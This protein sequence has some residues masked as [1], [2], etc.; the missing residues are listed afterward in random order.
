M[1]PYSDT[2]LLRAAW[3]GTRFDLRLAFLIMAPAGILSVLPL[4][5]IIRLDFLQALVKIYLKSIS[6]LMLLFY[7]FD[8]GHYGYLGR[9]IDITVLDNLINPLISARMI[10]ESYSVPGAVLGWAAA[11]YLIHKIVNKISGIINEAP[12]LSSK[13]QGLMGLVFGGLIYIF[14]IWGTFSQYPLRWSDAFFSQEAFV[15]AL[16]INP[17][18]YFQ[19]TKKFSNANFSLEETRR[20]Y[21]RMSAYLSVN[22]SPIDSLSFTRISPGT[23]GGK[24]P[25]IVIIFLESVGANRM[26]LMGN[27]LNPSPNLDRLA[28]EGLFFKRFYVP[29]VGTARSVFTLVTG[30]PDVAMVKTSSRN[31]LIADQFSIINTFTDYEKFYILGGSASWANIRGLIKLNIPGITIFEQGDLNSPRL[32]VWGISDH[33]LF[34]EAHAIFKEVPPEKPFFA[35][36]QTATNHKPYSI[37]PDLKN[38]EVLTPALEELN[39]AGFKS[40]D[41]Y[42][43]MRAL[44][45]ALGEYFD[46][47]READY[48]DN[49]L[50]VFFGDHGTSDPWA[51]HMPPADYELVLRS[52]HVPLIINGAPLK[53]KG[54][55]RAGVTTLADIMP[56][57]AALAGLPY[58]NRTMG[59]DISREQEEERYALLAG[60][61]QGRRRIGVVG[62]KYYLNMYTDGTD[63]RLFDIL[64]ENPTLDL[65]DEF[66]E[67][68]L[69][70]EEMTRAMFETAKYMLYHNQKVDQ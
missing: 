34:Q 8:F 33:N 54:E 51:R 46:Y 15:S 19:D 30:I 40:A 16:G 64:A 32:D 69:K 48:F 50:F 45:H 11:F 58:E 53:F 24:R 36:I 61:S 2:E 66:P 31:P 67:V 65:K 47:A 38:F 70:Y 52:Y 3:I 9:R 56:T 5:N 21:P 6:F 39:R 10:W 18:L 28:E 42:N 1:M 37:S 49:T 26:G 4:I 68:A 63:I 22:D 57:L 60:R 12:A 17:V 20:F 43:A 29:W 35:V 7:S 41:Q 25:N 13:K 62:E 55:T 59:R 23:A 14:G 27:P 44:D